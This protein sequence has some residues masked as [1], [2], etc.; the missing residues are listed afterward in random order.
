MSVLSRSFLS[1]FIL[2]FSSSLSLSSSGSFRFFTNAIL[3]DPPVKEK[4]TPCNPSPCGAN[5]LCREQNGAGSCECVQDY[6]G[7]PYEGCRP[8]C[9]INTECSHDRACIGNKCRDPCPGVCASNADC[10]AVN[11]LPVCTCLPGYSGDPFLQCNRIPPSSKTFIS[12]NKITR[13]KDVRVKM[14]I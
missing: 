13:C 8:E 6:T 7:N 11:H 4:P 10:R 3:A 2:L 5:A 1:P 12:R 14:S 9:I